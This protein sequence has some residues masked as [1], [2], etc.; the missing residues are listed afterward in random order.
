MNE[1]TTPAHL[2]DV[3]QLLSKD[4]FATSHIWY[5]GTAS[6]VLPSIQN[7][8]LV[9]SGDLELLAR[10]LKTLSTIGHESLSQKDPVFLTQSK[11]LAYFWAM[12]KTHTRNLY[13][14]ANETPIVL[15]VEFNEDQQQAV[16]TDAG[17]AAMLLEPGNLYLT[18]LRERY[19]SQGLTLADMDPFQCDRMDY[20]NKLGLAYYSDPIPSAQIRVV[21]PN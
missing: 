15:E 12:Q 5:H 16:I 14:G 6:G 10:Q 20:L 4:G 1:Y 17:G 19:E 3:P 21:H 13:M 18:W 2:Q 11:E 7:Y 8:G 9:G